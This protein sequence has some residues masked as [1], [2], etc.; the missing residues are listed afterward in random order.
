MVIS[1]FCLIMVHNALFW[2]LMIV[3]HSSALFLIYVFLNQKLHIL[4]KDVFKH[5]GYTCKLLIYI[6]IKIIQQL[7]ANVYMKDVVWQKIHT[8]TLNCT[9]IYVVFRSFIT[10]Y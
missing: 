2:F 9:V 6:S 10:V 4:N 3:L 5:H 8:K 7:L 1:L